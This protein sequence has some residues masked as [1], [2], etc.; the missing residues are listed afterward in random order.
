MR[1][2]ANRG[3]HPRPSASRDAGWSVVVYAASRTW[4][5]PIRG[6]DRRIW[7][8]WTC[9]TDRRLSFSTVL[10]APV[11]DTGPAPGPRSRGPC[12]D[13]VSTRGDGPTVLPGRLRW[14]GP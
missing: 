1:T 10:V 9:A 6:E 12:P 5:A 3:R 13:T 14:G 4:S 8:R 2:V 7:L 11:E